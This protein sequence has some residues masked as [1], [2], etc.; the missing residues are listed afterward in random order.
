[1]DSGKGSQQAFKAKVAVEA[2]KGQ[3]TAQELGRFYG[4]HPT[5]VT[6]GKNSWWRKLRK[7]SLAAAFTTTKAIEQ[8]RAG[9]ISRSESCRWNW[10]GFKKIRILRR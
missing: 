6:L 8:E 2:I 4:V 5:Q 10:T 1:M 9:S 3:R 7:F